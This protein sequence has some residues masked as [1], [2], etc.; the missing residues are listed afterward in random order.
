MPVTWSDPGA[1]GEAVRLLGH[2]LKKYTPDLAEAKVRVR[3]LFAHNVDGPALK[4]GGYPAAAIVRVRSLKQRVDTGYDAEVAIDEREWDDFTTDRKAA[5]LFHELS[6]LELVMK[7]VEGGRQVLQR[8]DIG[9]P[10]LKVKP[11]DWN[12]GDGFVRVVEEF[13]EEALEWENADNAHQLAEAALRKAPAGS[14]A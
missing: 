5:V 10:K 3:V 8:D 6:H 14:A 4:R 9:R 11:G 12:G 2:V 1:D 7:E 13:G